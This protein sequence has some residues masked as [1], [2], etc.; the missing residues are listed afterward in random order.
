MSKMTAFRRVLLI[1]HI[2]KGYLLE[3]QMSI[4]RTI[5]PNRIM[6]LDQQMGEWSQVHLSKAPWGTHIILMN[7]NEVTRSE[8]LKSDIK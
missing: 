8:D 5:A 3:I 1:I 4:I 7:V 6:M 2:G